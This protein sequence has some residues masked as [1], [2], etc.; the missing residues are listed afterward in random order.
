LAAAMPIPEDP[1]GSGKY[2][3]CAQKFTENLLTCEDHLLTLQTGNIFEFDIQ[4]C[5][6]ELMTLFTEARAS[7]TN[8]NSL[9]FL[10]GIYSVRRLELLISRSEN[11][12]AELYP[13][14]KEPK[15]SDDSA[16]HNLQNSPRW[17]SD[18]RTVLQACLFS[19]IP[20]FMIIVFL[21]TPIWL[22]PFP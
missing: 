9:D 12:N 18:S 11:A 14:Q 21:A 2:E 22:K 1:P 16:I 20:R 19:G 4:G 13:F 8:M 5:H 10:T 17:L 7:G 15:D 6:D 3:S